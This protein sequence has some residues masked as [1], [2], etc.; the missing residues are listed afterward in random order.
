MLNQ[1]R[2]ERLEIDAEEIADEQLAEPF[3]QLAHLTE[4][5]ERDDSAGIEAIAGRKAKT[6]DPVSKVGGLN[7]AKSMELGGF[8]PPTSWVRSRRSAS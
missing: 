1:G 2:F 5:W 4:S 3:K 7:V 8:E 6:S